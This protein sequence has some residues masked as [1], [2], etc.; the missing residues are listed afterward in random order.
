MSG[1]EPVTARVA[2]TS[3]VF[4]PAQLVLGV[5]GGLAVGGAMAL[6]GVAAWW[7]VPVGLLVPAVSVHQSVVRIAVS[8]QQVVVA[9]GFWPR[10]GRTIDASAVVEAADADLS[11]AQ[12]F[13]LGVPPHLRT[14][15]LTIRPGATLRLRLSD[16]E[17]LS[18]S[19]SDPVAA[20]R[21][22]NPVKE[23]S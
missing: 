8:P 16:G 4:A 14:N 20:L 22:L 23:T 15:R 11:W 13:G 12:T 21:L 10:R 3:T 5:L 19:T 7:S 9:Q 1:G 2:Y 18:V 6:G 17:R